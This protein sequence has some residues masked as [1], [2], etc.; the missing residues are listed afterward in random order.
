MDLLFDVLDNVPKI[1]KL[2]NSA[3]TLWWFVIFPVKLSYLFFFRRLILRLRN[4]KIWWW[5]VVPFTIAAGL[6]CLAASWLTCPYFTLQGVMCELNMSPHVASSLMLLSACSGPSASYRTIRDTSITTVMDVVTDVL[7]VSFPI[8]LLWKVRINMHQKL[9]LALFLC[10]SLV[11]VI[12]AIVRIAGINL[13]GGNVDIVWLAFWMQ[14]ECSIAVIMVASSAFRSLLVVNTV[15]SPSPGYSP[16]SWKRRMLRRRPSPNRDDM[17]SANGL[18]QVPRATLTGMRTV[19]RDMRISAILPSRR[20]SE[21][22]TRLT[23]SS[24]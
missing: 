6:A 12:V 7:I 17:E 18:P 5:C 15:E 23:E 1:A 4:L 16:G 21:G 22:M 3:S 19:I 9:G 13:R 14:Q 10:L 2:S 8:T 24:Q 20:E 11:M